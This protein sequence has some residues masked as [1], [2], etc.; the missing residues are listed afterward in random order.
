MASRRAAIALLAGRELL[1]GAGD[2]RGAVRVL[3]GAARACGAWPRPDGD[4]VIN[5]PESS[6]RTCQLSSFPAT[7]TAAGDDCDE[8]A[9]DPERLRR[10][11][12]GS[13]VAALRWS[14]DDAAATSV[15]RDAVRAGVWEHPAQRPTRSF[16]RG[17]PRHGALPPRDTYPVVR[18]AVMALEGAGRAWLR[19]LREEAN[20]TAGLQSETHPEVRFVHVSRGITGHRLPGVVVWNP[21]SISQ[22]W[23]TLPARRSGWR[24][25]GAGRSWC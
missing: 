16:R 5:I 15:A 6:S 3:A 20:F 18:D 22:K 17:L 12:L 23:L 14:G 2:A 13:L 8:L 11:V 9:R 10:E 4:S 1:H 21:I 25:A 19:E 7:P 24:W